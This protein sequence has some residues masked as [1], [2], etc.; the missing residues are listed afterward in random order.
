MATTDF[1]LNTSFSPN[2]D[3]GLTAE[4]KMP[5][6]TTEFTLVND[7]SPSALDLGRWQ[8]P[9]IPLTPDEQDAVM[10]ESLQEQLAMDEE[11]EEDTLP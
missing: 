3:L 6:G 9:T 10:A 2:I 5:H 4:V 8:Q 1:T 11:Q 7:F